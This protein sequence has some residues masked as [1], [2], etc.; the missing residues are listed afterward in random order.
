LLHH[1]H[2]DTLADIF[3]YLCSIYPYN[4]EG[5]VVKEEDKV[6]AEGDKEGGVS[7]WHSLDIDV[8]NR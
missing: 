1:R 8:F 6:E 3:G 5:E 7:A 2:Q 4:E